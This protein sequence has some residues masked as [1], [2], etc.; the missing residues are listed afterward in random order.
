M[1]KAKQAAKEFLSM[2]GKHKTTVDQDVRGA[3]TEEHVRPQHHE[4][5]TTA[6]DKEVHQDHHQTRVQPVTHTE[7]LPEK[8]HHNVLPVE[9]KTVEHGN[10]RD[11]SRRLQQDAAQ[12]KNTSTIESSTH[13]SSVAPTV[14]GERI[15]HHVHEHIQPVIQKQTIAPETTHTTV[16]IH[17]TH[18]AAPVHHDTTT[19]PTKTLEEFT[20]G[21]GVETLKGRGQ[22]TLQEYEGCPKPLQQTPESQRAIHGENIGRNTATSG[23][24][25]TS[26]GG[27][28]NQAHSGF[29]SSSGTGAGAGAASAYSASSTGH[30]DRTNLGESGQHIGRDSGVSKH[31]NTGGLG[32][33]A[34]GGSAG[35]LDKSRSTGTTSAT[36]G[37]PS[38]MDR[39]NPRKDADGDADNVISQAL[40]S[41]SHVERR[42]WGPQQP[43]NKYFNLRGHY[44]L[45]NA[46]GTFGDSAANEHTLGTVQVPVNAIE[47]IEDIGGYLRDPARLGLD[48]FV[49]PVYI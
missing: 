31:M 44:G 38:L 14:A 19:L 43:P 6:V 42:R 3:V 34:S 29:N 30:S 18:H 23:E 35:H 46:C 48:N 41:P 21:G 2:D 47:E 16:P 25:L 28:E 5:I 27:Y 37:K 10:A 36:S 4:N 39:L 24:N 40:I 49:T 8:H 1:E 20:R 22:H 7:T 12:Y 17:E 26:G 9:H 33:S 45:K 13:T 11:D 15:H 32:H